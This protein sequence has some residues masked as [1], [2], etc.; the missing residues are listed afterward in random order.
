[1]DNNKEIANTV[2]KNILTSDWISKAFPSQSKEE[3]T[4]LLFV[5]L[6]NKD[7]G[8]KTISKLMEYADTPEKFKQYYESVLE[9]TGKEI[10]NNLKK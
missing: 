4:G 7:T 6:S 8:K 9:K 2:I 5:L 10:F 3:Y 1:M